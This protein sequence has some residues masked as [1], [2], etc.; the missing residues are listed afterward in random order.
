MGQPFFT[1]GHSTRTIEE[2]VDL[3]RDS[4]VTL[5]VDVRTIP[6]SRA[7][8]QYN[9]DTLPNSLAAFQIGYEHI[10]EL[11]GLR[12]KKGVDPQINGF[13]KN[14]SFHNYADY[15]LGEAF[16]QGFA[17]LLELGAEQRCAIM[18]AEAVWWR[19]H[20]RIIADY[21]LARGKQVFHILGKGHVEP[22]TMT[23]SAKAQPDGAVLY[24]AA[25][26]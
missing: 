6:R 4:E 7:N 22:A 19:C 25:E 1:I 14:K 26:A 15:A 23:P 10:A 8:P 3:L 17:R 11:G 16:H 2:F 5:V 24:P 12:A 9:R 20:R 13:W 21:L 18:C